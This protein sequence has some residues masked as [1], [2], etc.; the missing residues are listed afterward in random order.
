VKIGRFRRNSGPFQRPPGLVPEFLL[1][2][3]LVPLPA[4]FPAAFPAAH[5]K[6]LLDR[7]RRKSARK[8]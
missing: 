3:A 4:A 8:S 7:Q 6:R 1:W 2:A 5:L